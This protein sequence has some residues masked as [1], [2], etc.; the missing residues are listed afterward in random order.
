[1]QT[2]SIMVIGAAAAAMLYTPPSVAGEIFWMYSVSGD[3]VEVDYAGRTSGL[4]GPTGRSDWLDMGVAAEGDRLDL[5]SVFSPTEF[6]GSTQLPGTIMEAGRYSNRQGAQQVGVMLEDRSFHVLDASDPGNG[7]PSLFVIPRLPMGTIATDFEISGDRI[8]I[9]DTGNDRMLHYDRNTLQMVG[10]AAFDV[11]LGPEATFARRLR[12]SKFI[13]ADGSNTGWVY[14]RGIGGAM[15]TPIMDISQWGGAVGMTPTPAPT[16][17][18]PIG[19]GLLLAGR[20]R[21]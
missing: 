16:T 20:R 21:R 14:E 10:A 4:V 9:L 13:I 17:L 12:F 6:L 5:Y 19:L 2:T 18:A 1:M 11:D 8:Y 7:V 15:T 3:I